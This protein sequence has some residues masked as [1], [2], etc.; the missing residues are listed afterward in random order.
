MRPDGL[1]HLEAGQS[2][3]DSD[4]QH[5]GFQ[6]RAHNDVD[7]YT[8]KTFRG[9]IRLMPQQLQE[10]RQEIPEERLIIDDEY[11]QCVVLPVRD[12]DEPS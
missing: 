2:G 9:E 11:F 3:H 4:P 10:L 7:A 5:A 6:F 12:G 8:T 1:G